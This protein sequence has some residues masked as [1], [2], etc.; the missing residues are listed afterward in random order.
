MAAA[1]PGLSPARSLA[2]GATRMGQGLGPEMGNAFL[3][4]Y[5]RDGWHLP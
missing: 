1:A 4:L 2:R 3:A 5:R